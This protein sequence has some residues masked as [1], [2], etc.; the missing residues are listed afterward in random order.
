MLIRKISLI[1][2]LLFFSLGAMADDDVKADDI[3]GY[4]LTE[5]KTGVIHIQKGDDNRYFGEIVWVKDIH[6]GKAKERL[7][8]ENPDEKLRSR[9]ILGLKNTWGFK[10]DGDDEWVDGS[11]YDPKSGKTYSAK[12]ELDDR[13]ELELRGYVGVPLFGKT[14]EW[15]REK[16]KVPAYMQK[17]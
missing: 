1:F 6:T 14:T 12:M 4:W 2:T 17:K 9:S 5:E 3:L 8:K 7:D 15:T 13:D 16:S 11:I 10:F